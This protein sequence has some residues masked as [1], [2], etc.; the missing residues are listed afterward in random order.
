[1]S[2]PVNK[3]DSNNTGLR[4]AEEECLRELP[5][6]TNATIALGILTL[7]GKGVEDDTFEIGGRTYT[8]RDTFND[9][10]DEII[11]GATAAETA[12]RIAEALNSGYSVGA[13]TYIGTGTG[14]NAD[15][16]AVQ[17][18]GVVTL[19]AKTAGADGNTITTT[20]EGADLSFGAATL[21]GGKDAEHASTVWRVLEPNSYSD[22][23][24]QIATVARNPINPSRQRKKGVTTDLDASGGFNQD[25]TLN[26][27]TRLLQGFFFAD[28]REK[29]GTALMNSAPV[30]V[31]GVVGASSEYTADDG[32]A[33]F[34]AGQLVLFSGFSSTANNGVKK[35]ST[36]SS[37]TSLKVTG[38]VSPVNESTPSEAAKAQVVGFEF[39]ASSMSTSSQGALVRLN[40]SGTNLTTLGLIRGEWIFVGGDGSGKHFDHSTGFAR[41]AD[42]QAGYIELDKVSWKPETENGTGITLQ[43]FFGSVLR[44]EDNPDL[45][46]RRTYQLERTLGR[47]GDGPMSE[48]L[49]GAVPNELTLNIAQADKVNIDM[50]FVAVD[51]E[52]RSG[53]QGL[54]MGVRPA[55]EPADAFNTSSDFS[56][57][58]LASVVNDAAPQP[59]FAFATEMNI[60]INNNVTP[61]KAIAVLGAF[62]TSAGTFE[63]GGSM[64]AY[65]ASVEAVQA[66]RNNA[67]ITL[68][69]IMI[70]RNAGMLFDI[71]LL[72]LGDGRLNVEQDQPITVPLETNAAESK[73]GHT[74]LF[75]TFP[76][77]P[78][79][80]G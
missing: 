4:Y 41:V 44:N 54:K 27:T 48:Y 55:L 20:S 62:D 80:A 78:N 8:L 6:G 7:I 75:Q 51:N 32:L 38:G 49:V 58:K 77:L 11:I 37:S 12:Q 66:V 19:M 26:N 2:C 60:T 68:D 65:F 53:S 30:L 13:A 76:Y 31:T 52:Q 33:G 57:I 43:I 40:S 45:I 72:S 59:L 61:N 70:K 25:L 28:I 67:D 64:T 15:V 56:R 14:A 74:L 17:N 39:A 29:H 47:D 63:V 69:A 35:V 21:V 46:K 1:M 73:Y 36:N 34:K 18:S 71:P 23:G 16:D 24:G 42:I 10:T 79:V 3:I 9:N 5:E 22:F 50:A